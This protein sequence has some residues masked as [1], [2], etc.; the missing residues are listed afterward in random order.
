[1]KATA[2]KAS[3]TDSIPPAGANERFVVLEV[4]PGPGSE[5]PQHGRYVGV[6]VP[7]GAP[8]SS[9]LF[10]SPG[11]AVR[12]GSA[13]LRS[14]GIF[15]SAAQARSISQNSLP[16]DIGSGWHRLSPHELLQLGRPA[17]GWLPVEK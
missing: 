9:E 13:T 1:M 7:E 17:S 4:M 6:I 3:S 16:I 10:F 8:A 12:H 11:K 14:A 5:L 2:A 15:V